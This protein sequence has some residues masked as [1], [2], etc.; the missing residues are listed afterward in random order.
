MN[1]QYQSP[2]G[3]TQ[4]RPSPSLTPS[5]AFQ[6]V[7]LLPPKSSAMNNGQNQNL[8]PMQQQN[9]I[10]NAGLPGGP[11]QNQFAMHE[12][13]IGGQPPSLKPPQ[14]Q[15]PPGQIPPHL[16]QSSRSPGMGFPP[17]SNQ[18]PPGVPTSQLPPQGNPLKPLPPGGVPHGQALG[19][20][21]SSNQ[22]PQGLLGTQGP[23]MSG[24]PTSQGP[25]GINQFSMQGG[26]NSQ[27]QMGQKSENIA[28]AASNGPAHGF[29][30]PSVTG[31]SFGN[32]VQKFVSCFTLL[33]SYNHKFLCTVST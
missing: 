27:N 13:P 11:P 18:Q 12:P 8:P 22:M 1:P 30:R 19:P 14:G 9:H 26:L 25:P 3:F 33:E 29:A 16:Q 20:P 15:L 6:N 31:R 10:P 32:L 17:V 23:G 4:N 21:V 7:S 28:L 24:P 5:N 2:Q